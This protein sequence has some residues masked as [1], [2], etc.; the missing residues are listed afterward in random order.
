MRI[1]KGLCGKT[2][3]GCTLKEHSDGIMT[4]D[5]TTT[6]ISA[7]IEMIGDAPCFVIKGEDWNMK[8]NMKFYGFR[9]TDEGLEFSPMFSG[10]DR[11]TVLRESKP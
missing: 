5:M 9:G 8:V 4:E 7:D 3:A 1:W 10:G 6:I 11:W 2:L